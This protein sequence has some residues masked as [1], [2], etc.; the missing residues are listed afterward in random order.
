ML[1]IADRC[2]IARQA[3]SLDERLSWYAPHAPQQST[4]DTTRQNAAPNVARADEILDIWQRAFS[5]GDRES[6]TRRLSWEGLDRRSG[7]RRARR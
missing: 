5:P 7:L 6:F 4:S 1:S 2:A 3:A